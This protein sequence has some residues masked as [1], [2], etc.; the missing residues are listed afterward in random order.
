MA[1]SDPL[2]GN[3]MPDLASRIYVGGFA[4]T[5]SDVTVFSQP[6]RAVWVGS[7]GDLSVVY[8]DGSSDILHAVPAGT[9]LPIRV[10]QVKST[11]TTASNISGLY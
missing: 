5:K 3:V 2:Y 1:S 10:T 11:N 7:A 8:W 9:L 4:I 6:T